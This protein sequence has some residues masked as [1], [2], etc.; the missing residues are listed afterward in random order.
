MQKEQNMGRALAASFPYTLPVLAGYLFLSLAY[1]VLIG[2]NGFGPFAAAG[3]SLAVFGG[4]IQFLAVSL[5]TSPFH[6]LQ[7]LLIALAVNA[8]HVFYGIS[9][10]EKYRGTGGIKPFLIFAMTDETF[11]LLYSASP[12]EGVDR[13]RFYFFVSLLNYAYWV[14]GSFIGAFLGNHANFNTKGMDFVL[15]ALFVVILIERV[16]D[17]K[18]LFSAAVGLMSTAVC[19][20]LFGEAGFIIPAMALIAAILT[21]ARKKLEEGENLCA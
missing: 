2:V 7:A 12:P 1:G 5:L 21:L 19:R 18:T 15:T 3:I 16:K 10:L 11:S 9:M 20:V 6:P 8:R 14:T 4:S 17:K 13:K